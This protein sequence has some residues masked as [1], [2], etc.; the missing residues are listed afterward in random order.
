LAKLFKHFST[1]KKKQIKDERWFVDERQNCLLQYGEPHAALPLT[2]MYC[3]NV[4]VLREPEPALNNHFSEES[5]NF[6]L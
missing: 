2:V 5:L 4:T 6:D 3:R 1:K